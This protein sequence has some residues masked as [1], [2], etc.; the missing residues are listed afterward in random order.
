MT[1]QVENTSSSTN[2]NGVVAQGDDLEKNKKRPAKSTEQKIKLSLTPEP[3]HPLALYVA[4]IKK[5]GIKDIDLNSLV[6]E[7]LAL[8]DEQWWQDRLEEATPLEYRVNMALSD[9]KMREKLS[10]LLVN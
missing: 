5:R 4:E 2:K 8:V 3:E 6:I 10:K 1:Q 7:A 9:P